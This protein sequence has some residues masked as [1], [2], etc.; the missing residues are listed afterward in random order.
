MPTVSTSY[1]IFI[2]G[3]GSPWGLVI[4]SVTEGSHMVA[5]QG[6]YSGQGPD[7]RDLGH[8]VH[9]HVDKSVTVLEGNA[10]GKCLVN[11]VQ[12]FYPYETVP[13]SIKH[14]YQPVQHML[15][16]SNILHAYRKLI[17]YLTFYF[18]LRGHSMG[19]GKYVGD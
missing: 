3:Q 18:T 8:M 11:W 6:N 4:R 19:V 5:I 15:L 9:A 10:W 2:S 12:G 16:A 1:L 13:T 7:Q 17:T 14:S